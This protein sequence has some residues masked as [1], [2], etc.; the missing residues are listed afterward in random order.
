M[1]DKG[2]GKGQWQ[3]LAHRGG[4]CS[5]AAGWG[6]QATPWGAWQRVHQHRFQAAPIL[7]CNPCSRLFSLPKFSVPSLPAFCPTSSLT[8][9]ALIR[10]DTA[11]DCCRASGRRNRGWVISTSHHKSFIAPSI[12][13]MLTHYQEPVPK[14]SVHPGMQ[15]LLPKRGPSSTSHFLSAAFQSPGLFHRENG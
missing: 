7:P 4:F 15:Y 10:S 9:G 2:R 5:P 14:C 12:L 3:R 6:G 13:P 8:P 11:C 1:P